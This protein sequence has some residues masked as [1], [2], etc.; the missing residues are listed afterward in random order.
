[1]PTA[2]SA[3]AMDA[4][5]LNMTSVNEVCALDAGD[6]GVPVLGDAGLNASPSVETQLLAGFRQYSSFNLDITPLRGQD[7]M[8]R[9]LRRHP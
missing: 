8:L 1:M 3:G 4:A 2:P 6:H 9:C 5:I 7:S